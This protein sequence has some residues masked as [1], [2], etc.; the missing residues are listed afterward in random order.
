MI[1]NLSSALMDNQ[2][3]TMSSNTAFTYP[4]PQAGVDEA[5][6]SEGGIRPHWRYLLH[7]LQ[8]LGHDA[9]EERQK[10]ERR[11]LLDDAAT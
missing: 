5:Y 10:T 9:I 1:M 4:S 8:T 3:N 6:D 11:I 7:S 2:A